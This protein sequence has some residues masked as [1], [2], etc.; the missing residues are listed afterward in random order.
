MGKG[1][2][3]EYIYIYFFKSYLIFIYNFSIII[4][5]LDLYSL[6]TIIFYLYR[7]TIMPYFLCFS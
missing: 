4:D 7:P 2:F 1:F 3:C 5:P 6:Y